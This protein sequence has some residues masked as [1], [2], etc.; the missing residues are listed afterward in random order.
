M[1]LAPSSSHRYDNARHSIGD[2]SKRP[3]YV[4]HA[5]SGGA[6]AVT[7]LGTMG[8]PEASARHVDMAAADRNRRDWAS[9]PSEDSA[10]P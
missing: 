7:S 10:C 5:H 6:D 8:N 2:V 1:S 3:I 9:S 4:L